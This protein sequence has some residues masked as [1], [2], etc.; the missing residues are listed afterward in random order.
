MMR[1]KGRE[2]DGRGVGAAGVVDIYGGRG[3][4]KKIESGEGE[5]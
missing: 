4:R 1:R 5:R 2:R 3:G